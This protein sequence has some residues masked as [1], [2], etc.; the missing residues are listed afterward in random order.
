MESVGVRIAGKGKVETIR[1]SLQEPSTGEV[2]LRMEYCGICGSDLME[3]TGKRPPGRGI[4]GHECCA[5]VMRTGKGVRRLKEGSRVAVFPFSS[6]GECPQCK[7]G[8]INLCENMRFITST[9][10]GCMQQF[11]V[12]PEELLVELPSGIDPL[13]GMMVEPLA[14]ARHIVDSIPTDCRNVCIVGCGFLGLLTLHTLR[15]TRSLDAACVCKHPFQGDHAARLGASTILSSEEARRA[16]N[17]FD[18][19]VDYTSGR[20]EGTNMCLRLC[21]AG[22]TVIIAGGYPGICG[23]E[24]HTIQRKELRIRGVFCY[25]MHH[26]ASAA[27]EATQS[28]ETLLPLVTHVFPLS[29]AE[30]AFETASSKAATAAVKVAVEGEI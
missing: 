26:F 29:R 30:E 1:R 22:G 27:E 23:V 3:Y 12:L 11:L 6:C 16:K 24:L 28:A 2:L 20:G 8:S 5:V 4:P 9:P 7:A 21:R 13:V 25:T 18:A 14:V 15:H 17:A 19:V 10:E